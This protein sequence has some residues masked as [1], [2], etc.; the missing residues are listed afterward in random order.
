MSQPSCL[1]D[2]W[3]YPSDGFCLFRSF[4]KKFLGESSRDLCDS[5]GVC[6]PVVKDVALVRRHDLGYATKSSECRGVKNAVVV[7]LGGFPIIWRLTF[8]CTPLLAP[9]CRG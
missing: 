9:F 6:K 1:G 7:A 5:D 2:I 4:A 8:D 3:V